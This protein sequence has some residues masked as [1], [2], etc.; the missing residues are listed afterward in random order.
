[1]PRIVTIT[2][3][4]SID[5]CVETARV[6]EDGVGEIERR[7]EVAAGKGVN[8]SR[9]LKRLGL[10]SI[11]Y[12]G[13]GSDPRDRFPALMFEAGIQ[14]EFVIFKGQVR[15][16]ITFI[17]ISGQI[18]SIHLKGVGY[19]A[20]DE[21]WLKDLIA[22]LRRDLTSSD[23]VSINGSL[24]DG[25]DTATWQ[26]I[27][28]CVISK[29]ASL[30]ADISGDPLRNLVTRGPVPQVLKINLTES[31]VI[32]EAEISRLL[33]ATITLSSEI[34]DT[35]RRLMHLHDLGVSLPIITNGEKGAYFVFDGAIWSAV[36]PRQKNINRVGAGDAMFAFLL[37]RVCN[38]EGI[39]LQ[40]IVDSVSYAA[41]F[42]ANRGTVR[43]GECGLTKLIKI[44]EFTSTSS[45]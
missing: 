2:L 29:N 26:M 14:A 21:F 42:V 18:S 31:E 39:Q 20:L 34:Q 33:T 28:K 38:S 19:R 9:E 25:A 37:S 5:E 43:L 10:N 7:Y 35:C 36:A 6:A 22:R 24:P 13:T 11:V 40:D 1:M 12:C 30:W 3:N 4:S 15:H 44:G 32:E 8:V 17:D 41:S 23:I 45:N 27:G 16:N